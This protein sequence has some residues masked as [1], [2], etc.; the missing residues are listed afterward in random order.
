MMLVMCLPRES[1]PVSR[2]DLRSE[3]LTVVTCACRI[4]ADRTGTSS[5]VSHEFGSV[6]VHYRLYSNCARRLADSSCQSMAGARPLADPFQLHR[7]CDPQPPSGQ[8]PLVYV[9]RRPIPREERVNTQLARQLGLVDS[10]STTTC[11]VVGCVR[12]TAARWKCCS[13]C[14]N[15]RS[16]AFFS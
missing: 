11:A 6:N 14:R 8:D 9:R 1:L 4:Q 10:R 13:R 12:G 2:R 16:S 5:P 7:R 3:F 15:W